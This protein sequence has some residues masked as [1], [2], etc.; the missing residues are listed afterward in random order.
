MNHLW[1]FWESAGIQGRE[2]REGRDETPE[3]R[4]GCASGDCKMQLQI[5]KQRAC[6][7]SVRRHAGRCG[8]GWVEKERPRARGARHLFGGGCAR[9]AERREGEGRDWGRP[10]KFATP[11]RLA[12]VFENGVLSAAF[13]VVPRNSPS[14]FRACH[15]IASCLTSD[16]SDLRGWLT[17][18]GD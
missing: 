1:R 4:N 18:C 2:L 8:G 3:V 12:T 10:A 14:S 15:P 9:S 17:I 5:G 11:F 16:F 6:E 13:R 7:L